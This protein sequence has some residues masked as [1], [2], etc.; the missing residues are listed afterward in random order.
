M[1]FCSPSIPIPVLSTNQTLQFVTEHGDLPAVVT[2]G[3]LLADN[4]GE[5]GT[6]SISV[7]T[8]GTSSSSSCGSLASIKGTTE[9]EECSNRGMCDRDGGEC[10]CFSGYGAS[11]AKGGAG[12]VPDC[13]YRIGSDVDRNGLPSVYPVSGRGFTN[14]MMPG[15]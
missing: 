7:Y 14:P 9:S 11:N 4:T 1:R 13:G 12:M 2:D 8:D 5:T 15:A 10:L 3:S 6:G